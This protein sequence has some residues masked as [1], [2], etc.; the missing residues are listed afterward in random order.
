MKYFVQLIVAIFAG[1]V[2]GGVTYL[3]FSPR[4]GDIVPIVKSQRFELVDAEGNR[5]A[6]L[7]RNENGGTELQI[8][9]ARRNVAIRLILSS[10]ERTMS[11]V[12]SDEGRIKLS[13]TTNP[14]GGTTL[15]LGDSNRSRLVLGAIP[16]DIIP[17]DGDEPS[18]WG[19]KIFDPVS[20]SPIISLDVG[21]DEANRRGTGGIG[22]TLS[23]GR[24]V[25]F[26]Q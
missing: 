6:I 2:S 8:M 14:Q 15:T 23:D 4:Q 1:G 20:V 3:L 12:L 19:L 16:S 13:A 10:D 11:F 26:P 17:G 7:G 21:I 5:R 24:R 9:G 22:V 25:T 18:D